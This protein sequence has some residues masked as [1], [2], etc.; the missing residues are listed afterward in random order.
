M[1]GQAVKNKVKKLLDKGFGRV[2]IQ[3]ETGLSRWRTVQLM[4][5][6]QGGKKHNPSAS[7]ACKAE[8]KDKT[9]LDAINELAEELGV[10]PYEVSWGDFKEY[11]PVGEPICTYAEFTRVRKAYCPIKPTA[12][13][14]YE[15]QRQKRASVNRQV[16]QAY[17]DQ[18]ILIES[19]E[20]FAD[21]LF[22]GRV[23]VRN[24][25]A[26]QTKVKRVLNL[27]LSDLHIGSDLDPEEVLHTFSRS[28]ESRRLAYTILQA[29]NYKREHRAET[30]LNLY[31]NGDIVQGNL[32]DMRD[33]DTLAS[34]FARAVHL[35][36]QAIAY[37]AEEFDSVTVYCSTGNHGRF[38]SRHKQR[39]VHQKWDSL[40][41]CI[42]YA[43]K[44]ALAGV[45]HVTFHIP[46]TPFTVAEVFGFKIFTTHGDTVLNVGN[47]GE[48]LPLGS[49][50]KQIN[51]INASLPDDQEYA[52]FQVGHVHKLVNTTVSNSELFVNGALVPPDPFAIS[53]GN[54]ECACGQW[55]YESTPEHVVGDARKIRL[56]KSID[57]DESLDEVITPFEGFHS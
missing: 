30:R 36:M 7:R 16:S 4:K 34:Q 54:M 19:I 20:Q 50:E 6:L 53:L 43:L 1:T 49:I 12:E 18:Q 32:H 17:T 9:I 47:P 15:R 21:R 24:K 35:L 28:E 37:L 10:T 44:K 25:P 22:S 56:N 2:K 57:D 51:K 45:K 11:L 13:T 48:S 41:T 8:A 3:A 27:H 5:E 38:T 33:G 31:I 14:I 42:Y 46:K 26:K 29:A 55:M 52:V 39:A 40:E 23:E